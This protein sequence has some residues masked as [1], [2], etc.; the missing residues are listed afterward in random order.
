MLCAICGKE[1]IEVE[2]LWE[3]ANEKHYHIILPVKARQLSVFKFQTDFY[4]G[5]NLSGVFVADKQVVKFLRGKTVYFGEALGKHSDVEVTIDNEII[6]VTANPEFVKLF[7]DLGLETGHNPVTE[8][9][10]AVYGDND[11]QTEW[12]ERYRED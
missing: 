4:R 7:Q 8:W 10:D 1:I 3:H 6:F 11:W 9:A 2:G 12:A 5:G